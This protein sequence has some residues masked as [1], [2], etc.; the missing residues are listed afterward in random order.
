MKGRQLSCPLQ[1]S[2]PITYSDKHLFLS[3]AGCVDLEMDN[4]A[5][6]YDILLAFRHEFARRLDGYFRAQFLEVVERI[7]LGLL[8]ALL[9]V[10]MNFACRLRCFGVLLDR[11]RL[12]LILAPRRTDP[13]CQGR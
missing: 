11:P 1:H 8:E 10:T 6:L 3:H 12:D 13:S 5:V 9:K 7:N 2:P 4:V